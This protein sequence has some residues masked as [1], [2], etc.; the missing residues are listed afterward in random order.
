VEKNPE[1]K[2]QHAEQRIDIKIVDIT[3]LSV[4]AIVSAANRSP[5]IFRNKERI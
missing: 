4:D 1:E 5:K 3:K 2:I